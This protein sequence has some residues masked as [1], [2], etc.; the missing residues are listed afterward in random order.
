MSLH[1]MPKAAINPS[2][3][4]TQSLG[5]G[6]CRRYAEMKSR[7]QDTEARYLS[8]VATKQ[9][10]ETSLGSSCGGVCCV[11]TIVWHGDV[12]KMRQGICPVRILLIPCRI[13]PSCSI[14]SHE[15]SNAVTPPVEFRPD[16]APREAAGK[17]QQ[18]RRHI[19]RAKPAREHSYLGLQNHRR[20][21]KNVIILQGRF[22]ITLHFQSKFLQMHFYCNSLPS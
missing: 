22:S 15:R 7:S 13:Q 14:A 18:R 10:S 20:F 12:A 6:T 8:T 19:L 21:F 4:S 11:I 5:E 16:R 17:Q 9:L 3:S 1:V 2:A